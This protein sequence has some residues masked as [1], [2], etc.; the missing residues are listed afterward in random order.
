ME[1]GLEH[2][3]DSRGISSALSPTELLHNED[4]SYNIA[5]DSSMNNVLGCIAVKK[6]AGFL[7]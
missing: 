7:N 2:P 1:E 6:V 5:G 3:T 4:E